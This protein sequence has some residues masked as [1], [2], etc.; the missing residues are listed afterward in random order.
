MKNLKVKIL[1]GIPASGKSTWSLNYIRNNPD[2][3]RVSRDDLVA[4]LR[5]PAE[6]G[7]TVQP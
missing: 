4:P 2:W 1:I 6:L 3:T 7:S 5:K